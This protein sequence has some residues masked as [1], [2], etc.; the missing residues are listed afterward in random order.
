MTTLFLL[1]FALTIEL[2]SINLSLNRGVRITF[3]PAAE[4]EMKREGTVTRINITVDPLRPPATL[5]QMLNT[6]VVWAVSP[7]GVYENLGELQIDRNKGEF[8]GTTRLSQLGILITAEPH[9]MVDRPSSAVA[10]RSQNTSGTRRVTI[11]AQVGID[12]YSTLKPSAPAVHSSVVQARTAVQIAQSVDAERIAAS[13]FRQARVALGSMEELITRGA[14]LEI[15]WPTA[16]EAIRSGQRAVTATREKVAAMQLEGAKAELQTLGSEK[17]RLDARIRELTQE[18]AATATQIRALQESVATAKSETATARSEKEEVE[19]RAQ[20]AERELAELKQKQ[21]QL[22]GR[23]RITLST[24]LFDQNG[25]TEAG[26]DALIRIHNIAEVIPGPIRLEGD[27]SENA[28]KAATEFLILA[29]IPQDRI[30][31]RR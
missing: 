4:G 15:L 28:L 19:V 23:L 1:L 29:G 24:D 26:R 17:Q 9:Y 3:A 25:L 20:R 11:Q 7:E 18:Q 27:A 10:Y 14:P 31:T 5:G 8:E 21:E 2:D 30:I 16:N 12:D 6:Y 13:E 22:Q